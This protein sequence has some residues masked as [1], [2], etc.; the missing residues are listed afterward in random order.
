[1]IEIPA[2]TPTEIEAVLVGMMDGTNIFARWVK[3]DDADLPDGGEETR[4]GYTM[5]WADVIGPDDVW[6]DCCGGGTTPAEAAAA[7]WVQ[8]WLGAW[9]CEERNPPGLTPEEVTEWLSESHYSNLSEEEYLSVP[10]RVP[11]GYRFKFF[12]VPATFAGANKIQ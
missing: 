9:W 2:P 3:L 4:M 5:W 10:R 8:V 6:C 7:A 11:E 12:A 1:M